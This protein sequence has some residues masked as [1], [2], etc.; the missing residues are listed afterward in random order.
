MSTMVCITD[1]CKIGVI[2]RPIEHISERTD[3]AKRH[4]SRADPVNLRQHLI[5]D[6][7]RDRADHQQ[8]PK[9]PPL[10]QGQ[11]CWTKHKATSL[12]RRSC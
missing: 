11:D 8:R 2:G 9:T 5:L 3:H 4:Q 7:H 12:D 6:R 10:G 1:G